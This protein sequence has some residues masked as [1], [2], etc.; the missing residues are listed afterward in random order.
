M[1]IDR[2]MA[3]EMEFSDRLNERQLW[4]AQNMFGFA[5]IGLE[6]WATLIPKPALLNEIGLSEDEYW[7]ALGVA[8]LY[9][10]NDPEF[11]PTY[12]P[13]GY[14]PLKL[15]EPQLTTVM[16]GLAHL[17]IIDKE[18]AVPANAAKAAD[19][20][21]DE[22]PKTAKMLRFYHGYWHRTIKRREMVAKM[23][24]DLDRKCRELIARK[25]ARNA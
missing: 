18:E 19:L 3:A 15:I 14:V 1:N 4:F 24:E 22:A 17:G 21:A 8:I 10:A 6:R 16:L 5:L 9:Y 25:E 12:K 7:E 13:K 11:W 23:E 2:E 20:I